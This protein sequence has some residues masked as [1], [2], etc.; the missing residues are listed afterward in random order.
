MS[1]TA[2]ERALVRL[3]AR[4]QPPGPSLAAGER[5]LLRTL[6]ADGGEQRLQP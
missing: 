3:D 5:E 6:G 4:R 1:E 2:L